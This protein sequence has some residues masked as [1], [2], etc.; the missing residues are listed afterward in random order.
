DVMKVHFD[1]A[2]KLYEQKL[3]PMLEREHGLGFEGLRNLPLDDLKVLALRNDDRIVKTLLLSALAPNVESLRG[4]TAGKLAALNHGT[5]RSP[6]PGRETSIV[7]QKCRKWAAEVGQIKIG[8]EPTNPSISVQLTGVDTESI[9]LQAQ[10][11]DNVGN[12]IR[13][14]K[15]IL[16]EQL[17]VEQKDTL[18]LHHEFMWRATRRACEILFANIR[19][20][21]D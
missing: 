13:K 21:P 8:D 12:R 6:I 18:I 20:L 7:L 17:G 9:I 10:A 2:K 5:I 14:I 1:N 11:E 19:E 15:D 3:K 16:F 4:L